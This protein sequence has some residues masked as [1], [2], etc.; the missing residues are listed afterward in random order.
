MADITP[1]GFDDDVALRPPPGGDARRGRRPRHV[2]LP[3]TAGQGRDRVRFSFPKRLETLRRAAERLAGCARREPGPLAARI[4]AAWA[5]SRSPYGRA[6]DRAEHPDALQ[7]PLHD[8]RISVTDRCNFRCVYCMPKEVFGR[9]FQFLPRD[10]PAD[11]RGD[12]PAGAALRRPRRAQRSASPAASPCCG[13]S[14][15]RLVAMLAGD[16]GARRPDPDHE[17]LAADPG[18]G[19]RPA[20]RRPAAASPSAWTRSTTPSSGR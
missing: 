14:W 10:G 1:F 8:L 15:R 13:A 4:I 9:D 3:G 12:H 16:R 6:P 18:Q 17:R 2:L 19:A 20:G 5:P 11:V 7:R